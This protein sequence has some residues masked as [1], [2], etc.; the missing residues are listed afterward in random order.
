[1]N[2]PIKNKA[3]DALAFASLQNQFVLNMALAGNIGPSPIP[4]KNLT[5]Y[6]RP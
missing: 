5:I 6:N 2:L 1:M 4:N 3:L